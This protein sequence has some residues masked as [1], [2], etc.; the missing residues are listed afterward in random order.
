MKKENQNFTYYD[1]TN[2]QLSVWKV[3]QFYKEANLN[4][5]CGAYFFKE[6]IDEKILLKASRIHFEEIDVTSSIITTIKDKDGNSVP[7]QYFDK[8]LKI[9]VNLTYLK[10]EDDFDEFV[11]LK[12]SEIK[13]NG[14]PLATIQV[15]KLYDGKV[16]YMAISHHIIADAYSAVIIHQR[17]MEIYDLLIKGEKVQ[18]QYSSFENY[19]K[20][21]LKYPQS[22]RFQKDKEYWSSF[23]LSQYEFKEFRNIKNNLN[24]NKYGLK[25]AVLSLDIN[26]AFVEKMNKFLELKKTTETIFFSSLYLMYFAL[27]QNTDKY[28]LG[29]PVL[30]RV[31]KI[32]RTTS[33]M[34]INEVPLSLDLKEIDSIDDLLLNT[35]KQLTKILRHQKY[36]Y[37]Y[38]LD[39]IREEQNDFTGTHNIVFSY[40]LNK[41]S[42]NHPVEYKWFNFGNILND[43]EIHMSN[44]HSTKDIN[45]LYHYKEAK[46]NEEM[47][48]DTHER[49]IHIANTII[50]NELNEEKQLKISEIDIVLPKE[51]ENILNKY[52]NKKRVKIEK[53]PYEMFLDQLLL[54]P[55]KNAIF[56]VGG[57]Y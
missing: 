40:Q 11:K 38:T 23:D 28:A 8:N 33:G 54:D 31:N 50:D 32:E 37:E 57:G 20:E 10:E 17:V 26:E 43:I 52:N 22:K 2:P 55:Q 16:G 27:L 45:V 34:F 25:A 19:L 7:K 35:K 12:M 36:S 6:D 14:G 9:H 15:F 4:I 47:I 44:I 49:I 30:N 39:D 3:D 41:I 21:E 42:D 13:L 18:K 5:L 1:L 24:T 48:K 29:F 56:E 51:K 53:T 46:F